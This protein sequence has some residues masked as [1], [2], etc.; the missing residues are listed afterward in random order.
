[1]DKKKQKKK[2]RG[3]EMRNEKQYTTNTKGQR[4]TKDLNHSQ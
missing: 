1:M 2:D 4:N 3:K